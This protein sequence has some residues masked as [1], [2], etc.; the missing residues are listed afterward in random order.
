MTNQNTVI[1]ENANNNIQVPGMV[2]RSNAGSPIHTI[3]KKK[4]IFSKIEITLI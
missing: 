1:P 2:L 3:A 4:A